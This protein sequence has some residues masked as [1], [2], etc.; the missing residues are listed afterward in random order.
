ML[1]LGLNVSAAG[2]EPP[3]ALFYGLGLPNGADYGWVSNISDNGAVI[4]GWVR[5]GGLTR[6]YRWSDEAGFVLLDQPPFWSQSGVHALSAD[7]TTAVGVVFDGAN[8]LPCV[9]RISEPCTVLISPPGQRAAALAC[10]FDGSVITG[11]AWSENLQAALIWSGNSAYVCGPGRAVGVD[12]SGKIVLLDK[13][14]TL[15]TEQGSV[16]FGGGYGNALSPDGT[17]VAGHSQ[18]A[19]GPY[20]W[21][22][23]QQRGW[24]MVHD[25]LRMHTSACTAVSENGEVVAGEYFYG[26]SG[27][28]LWTKATGTVDLRALLAS[29]G[30]DVSNWQL[31]HAMAIS[32]DGSFI[33]GTGVYTMP[34][35]ST[36]SEPWRAR[37]L[38]M[39]ST[40]PDS[41]SQC[42]GDTA[43]LNAHAVG[44]GPVTYSW[45]ITDPMAN[46]GWRT[47]VDGPT[48]NGSVIAGAGTDAMSIQQIGLADAG[49]YRCRVSNIH[50]SQDSQVATITV[51]AADVDCSGFVDLDDY[52]AFVHRFEA[53]DDDA[54]FDRS[55]FVDTDDFTAFVLAFEQ[56]C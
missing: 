45:Q 12:R 6:A 5:I 37:L 11:T 50:G 30:A 46:G 4:A 13:P 21:A 44:V 42:L 47:L 10:N 56:G 27:T 9:W 55:G 17:A 18:G 33:A 53:G 36:R 22:W 41:S 51:C 40:G 34:D 29:K 24:A 15:W 35:G 31:Q 2:G 16:V 26:A 32:S 7:G 25:S 23:S 8:A 48:G 52:G 14:P 39:I 43:R 28:L 1:G 54:D 20:G 19:S 38:L 49:T 3:T